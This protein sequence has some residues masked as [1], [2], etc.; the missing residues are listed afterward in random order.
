MWAFW[1]FLRL[2]MWDEYGGKTTTSIWAKIIIMDNLCLFLKEV[3]YSF[4]LK[5]KRNTNTIHLYYPWFNIDMEQSSFSL[6]IIILNLFF[7]S[8]QRSNENYCWNTELLSKSNI[9]QCS[10]HL[11]P[12]DKGL[13]VG[14]RKFYYNLNRDEV[15]GWRTRR[16]NHYIP[17]PSFIRLF[18]LKLKFKA[19]SGTIGNPFQ[20]VSCLTRDPFSFLPH[21]IRRGDS[22]QLSPFP[23]R[24]PIIVTAPCR[25]LRTSEGSQLMV[26]VFM[27]GA[28]GKLSAKLTPCPLAPSLRLA[29]LICVHMVLGL[30]TRLGVLE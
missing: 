12:I 15:L 6:E 18:H 26:P 4:R 5:A 23:L 3:L 2:A 24:D 16:Y 8:S 27:R 21:R 13:V 11:C 30:G 20:C 10:W 25:A 19:S 29:S 7:E 14:V 28:W 17:M 22:K 1:P 9:Q